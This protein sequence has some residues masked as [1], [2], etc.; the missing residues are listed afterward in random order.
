MTLA[1]GDRVICTRIERF[2][3]VVLHVFR[4]GGVLVDVG[5]LGAPDARLFAAD[6]VALPGRERY[7]RSLA[8][9]WLGRDGWRAQQ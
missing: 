6:E 4:S 2:T 7:W 1:H 8:S 9:V 5:R 3:G